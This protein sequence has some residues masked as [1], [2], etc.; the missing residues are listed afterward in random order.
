MRTDIKHNT[1]EHNERSF[2][3]V[4]RILFFKYMRP[5]IVT[6]TFKQRNK[7]LR[8]ILHLNPLQLSG[9]ISYRFKQ[10]YSYESL[11]LK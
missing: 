2:A 10:C 5:F 7:L 11:I 1:Y 6:I 8:N 9:H 3:N 4:F